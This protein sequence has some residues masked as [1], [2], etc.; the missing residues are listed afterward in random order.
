MVDDV[1]AKISSATKWSTFAEICAKLA[2]PIVNMILVRLLKPEAF[3][4]VAS[5]TII[6][7]FAD[8]FTDAGFQK[9]IIQHEYETSEE[10]DKGTAIAF[11]SNFVLS[12]II[13]GIILL[14]RNKLSSAIGCPDAAVGVVV[15]SLSVMCTAFS[16]T[17]IA[18]FKRELDFQPIFMIRVTSA[19]VP[20]IVT[21]PIA[22]WLKSYWAIVV[23]SVLQ[24]FYIAIMSTCLSKWKPRFYLR[25]E[26]FKDMLFYSIWNLCE[27]VSIWFTSQASVFI[28]AN[29]LDEYYLGLYK[30]GITAINSYLAIITASLT[31]VLFSVLSRYQNQNSRFIAT[32]NKFQI[33]LALLVLPLGA[34]IFMY[35][36]LAVLILLG[37][38]WFEV[39]TL[40]GLW[41]LIST[42]TITFSNTACEVYR[43]K[44]KIRISLIL[45]CIFLA[46]YVPAVY[47]SAK[48]GF[49]QLCYVGCF[50]RLVPVLFDIIVLK[51][52]IGLDVRQVIRN[53]K[54]PVLATII[55]CIFAMLLQMMSDAIW[56]QLVSIAL[57][58][59]VYVAVILSFTSTRKII[60]YIP[61]AHRVLEKFGIK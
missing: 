47:F 30:T 49:Q 38:R 39:T 26:L 33:L 31:P 8:I 12:V 21:V 41:A 61:M 14:L 32:V 25:I 46:Y 18:R 22:I 40:L 42:I 24:Q 44:G 59:G 16:G 17:L 51:A 2:A 11:T 45:Q 37:E 58:A 34:G 20:L 5:I 57:C 53:V 6:T 7:S 1:R 19:L 4:I 3:G 29:V 55:M 23:G 43:S 15:A 13:F 9:Y 27:S 48:S 28:V 35:R 50:I 52:I 60:Q 56:W 10:L 54:I 36:K